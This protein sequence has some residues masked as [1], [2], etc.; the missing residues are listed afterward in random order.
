M[1]RYGYPTWQHFSFFPLCI[2]QIIISIYP[3]LQSYFSLSTLS[4]AEVKREIFKYAVALIRGYVN[5]RF[6]RLCSLCPP[7]T[8][9]GERAQRLRHLATG[10][11]GGPTAENRTSRK[12]NFGNVCN[13]RNACSH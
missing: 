1:I 6:E 10:K 7:T 13:K 3:T 2:T 9:Q 11:K 8:W 4:R 12:P 5:E